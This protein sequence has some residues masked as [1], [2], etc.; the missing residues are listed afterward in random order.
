M[1]E[2]N[3][4]G[5][6]ID[7][8]AIDFFSSE[9]KEGRLRQ[10]WGWDK[11]QDLRNMTKDDGAKRNK[12]IMQRVKK[13]DIILI[14]RLP[15]WD[16]VMIARATADWNQ[17]YR[18]EISQG[19]TD[20]GHIFPAEIIRPFLRNASV[21]EGRVRS[22][23]RQPSRFWNVNHCSDEIEKI[24]NADE[25][26]T[27]IKQE[28]E[29]R[30][31]SVFSRSFSKQFDEK[32][33]GNDIYEAMTKQFTAEEWE[34]ALV[35]GLKQLFPYYEVQ[36]VGGR[37]ENNHGTDILIKLPDLFS[38]LRYAIAI[39]VKDYEGFVKEDVISQIKKA[40]AYWRDKDLTVIDKVVIVTR[41]E[42]DS[43]QHLLENEDGVKFY[44]AYN[45]EELLLAIG[46]S[47]IGINDSVAK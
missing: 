14:P 30:L 9:L 15:D 13:D 31:E 12:S 41:A 36:R 28:Y 38:E 22:T 47:F 34:Y 39:Q 25:T 8:R 18:F 33:F 19:Q 11:G 10:G 20:Y 2:R 45:L 26:E 24:I 21:V 1:R 42:K 43:N 46:K 44:F 4:W 7:T 6:R 23:L 3:Y 35:A 17:G 40:D 27:L 32:Q 16:H 29:E 37:A 5:Y